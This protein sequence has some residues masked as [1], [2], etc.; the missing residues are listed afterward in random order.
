MVMRF[1]TPVVSYGGTI[2]TSCVVVGRDVHLSLCLQV[3]TRYAGEKVDS[4]VG[5]SLLIS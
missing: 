3:G 4:G 2:V 1:A 5:L